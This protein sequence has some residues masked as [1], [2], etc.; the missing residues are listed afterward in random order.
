[1][2]TMD[3]R[4][5]L[6]LGDANMRLLRN[7]HVAVFGVG[8]VGGYVCEA[9]ARCGVGSLD[10]IDSDT[11]SVS[12]LNRQILALHSTV[13]RDK[14]EVMCER[15]ADIDSSVQVRTYKIFFTPENASD[16]DFSQYT[17]VVDAIDTVSGK[18]A[19]AE[20]CHEA[21]VPLI[22]SMGAGNKLHPEL[23][24]IADIYETSVCPLARVMRTEL[25][26]RGIPKLK[27]VYSKEIPQKPADGKVPESRGRHLPGSIS[28][29]PSA[30]GLIL[31]GAVVRDILNIE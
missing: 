23:F 16:F 4:T 1:M 18:I 20:H 5:R 30:A 3:S 31:A 11:V 7:A 12:N 10:L 29:T 22:S 13:G 8:G 19:L 21:N 9:L 17:Y 6:L 27:V 15:I 24:E 14:T 26:K 25:R 28:F 2:E